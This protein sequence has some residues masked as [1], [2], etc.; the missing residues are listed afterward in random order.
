MEKF[1]II[2]NIL[3][4]IYFH[5]FFLLVAF[6]CSIT[7]VFREF[8]IFFLIIIIHEIGHIIGGLYYNWPI[9][10]VIFLPF[11]GLTIFKQKLNTPLKEEFIV[12]LLGPLFQILFYLIC[13]KLFSDN[14]IL[15]KYHYPLLLFNLLPLVPLDGSKI[16]NVLLNKM[17]S[18]KWSHLVSII[19]SLIFDITLILIIILK[20]IDL[21][22]FLIFFFLMVKSFKELSNHRALVNKF[23]LER[24]LYNF[25]FTKNKLLQ[26]KKLENMFRD[27]HHFFYCYHRLYSEEELLRKRFDFKRKV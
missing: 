27:Y 11:G 10:K 12:T 14:I 24:Y 1:K 18:F 16:F 21:I 13:T 26:N 4:K 20:K 6:I 23:I 19:F 7:G 9:D 25:H 17:M 15:T 2:K 3:N 5:P 22:Y 8:T